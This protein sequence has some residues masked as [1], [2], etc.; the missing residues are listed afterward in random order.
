M[1]RVKKIIIHKCVECEKEFIEKKIGQVTCSK[2]CGWERV[3]KQRKNR[4][5]LKLNKKK[6]VKK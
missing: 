6:E 4:L 1:S 3:R 2:K 5:K